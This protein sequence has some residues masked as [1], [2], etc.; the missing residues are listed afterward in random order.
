MRSSQPLVNSNTTQL[1]QSLLFLSEF[2]RVDLSFQQVVQ[3][4]ENT[5][6]EH[7]SK[8]IPILTKNLD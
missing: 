5:W 7:E 4:K 2:E 8:G 3:K 6:R 1:F